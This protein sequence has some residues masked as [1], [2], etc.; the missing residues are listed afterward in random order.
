MVWKIFF[1]A[2]FAGFNP[3]KIIPSILLPVGSLFGTLSFKEKCKTV[4]V[5]GNLL[6]MAVHCSCKLPMLR[7]LFFVL[8]RFRLFCLF[9]CFSSRLDKKNQNCF[10]AKEN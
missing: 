5:F 3:K 6:S 8:T 10:I 2:F 1:P 9:D 4:M 7:P